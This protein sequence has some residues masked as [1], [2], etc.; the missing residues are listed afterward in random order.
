V[1]G[2]QILFR[3]RYRI[4]STR[5][6]GWNYAWAGWYFV[7]I[8][9]QGRVCCL[10][11]IRHGQMG[12]SWQGYIVNRTWHGLPNHYPNCILDEF[13]VMPNH[14]HG[15]IRIE[16]SND[17]FNECGKP[18]ETGLK[19]VSTRRPM[20][21]TAKPMNQPLSE[22]IRGFKTFSARL[23]NE[24]QGTIG[25]RFWQPR[26]HDRIIRDTDALEQIRWYIRNNPRVWGRDRNN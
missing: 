15:I 2:D 12:Q 22:I 10:G 11:D 21:P 26:Y 7:T 6:I 19:P 8:C 23:I 25:E 18:V 1:H 17:N 20:I 24:R 5:L 13:V 16:Y 14:I 4:P 3:N 9:T